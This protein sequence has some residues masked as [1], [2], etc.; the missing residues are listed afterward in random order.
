[1]RIE[2]IL[3]SQLYRM[4]W[5][6]RAGLPV[7]KVS[8][9]VQAFIEQ[10]PK[11]EIHVHFEGSLP[12]S[13][14][15]ALARKHVGGI[16]TLRQAEALLRFSN[17]HQFF[18]NFMAVSALL[19]SPEDFYEAA[20]AVGQRYRDEHIEYAELTLAPHKFIREGIAYPAMMEAIA[21]GLAEGAGGTTQFRFI[22]DIVRDLGP[23][24]G[25]EM[26]RI[27]ERHPLPAVVGIGLGGSEAFPPEASRDVYAFAKSIG[28]RKTAH[29][30]EGMGPES[31]RGAIR[32][33][34]VERIDHG[35]RAWEDPAVVELL[36][37]RQIP[38][39]LCVSSNVRLG[40]VP[41]L[42]AHPIR[43]YFEQ[44]L[45]VNCSTDDPPFFG[46]TL[47]D[48]LIRLVAFFRFSVWEIPILIQN[49]VQA[50]FIDEADKPRWLNRFEIETARLARRLGL[51]QS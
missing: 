9:Q 18:R 25:M 17:P 7:G 39:N 2:K 46:T 27:A 4:F 23:E 48:E 44:G 6:R 34:K 51:T 31:I 47:S 8:P 3:A 11:V 36:K 42:K 12:V 43:T 20:V 35:V 32:H 49:A 45:S 22:L 21:A 13:A 50:S 14:I 29:A 37:E 26:M 24:L 40:V 33:L 15:L 38:L 28:L 41:K 19:R 16:Q 30:G 10:I 5:A 1:M